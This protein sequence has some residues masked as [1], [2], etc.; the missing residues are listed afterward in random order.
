MMED[1]KTDFFEERIFTFTPRGDVIDLPI[2]SSVI[3]F[4]YA[5]HSDIGNHISSIMVNGKIAPLSAK[6]KN[7]DQVE[8]ITKNSAK[9]NRKWLDYTKTAMARKFIKAALNIKT[10]DIV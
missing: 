7:W 1:L 10:E 8:V 9:P 4:A 3:D 5:I 6:L 2:G